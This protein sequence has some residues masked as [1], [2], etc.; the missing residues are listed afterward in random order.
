MICP[1]C[2]KAGGYSAEAKRLEDPRLI[3][4][5]KKNAR[6]WH[7]QCT[8][9]GCTCQHRIGDYVNRETLIPK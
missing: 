4:N 3:K 5:A 7:K 8:G 2:K 1:A 6:A 9:S